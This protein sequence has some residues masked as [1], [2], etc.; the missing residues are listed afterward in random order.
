MGLKQIIVTDAFFLTEKEIIFLIPYTYLSA[1]W[2]NCSVRYR[3]TRPKFASLR[4]RFFMVSSKSS[5]PN[6]GTFSF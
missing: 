2:A 6:T 1:A 5:V 3:M 4:D